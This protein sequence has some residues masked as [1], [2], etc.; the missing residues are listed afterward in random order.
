MELMSPQMQVSLYTAPSVRSAIVIGGLSA[1]T[2]LKMQ[3]KE[4]VVFLS[5]YS[6]NIVDYSSNHH[7][8][9]IHPIIHHTCMMYHTSSNV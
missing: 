2:L 3:G 6:V 1:L 9:I 8:Q 4:E 5:S 7:H